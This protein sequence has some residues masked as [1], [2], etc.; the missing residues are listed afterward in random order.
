MARPRHKVH[1][2]EI[3][4]PTFRIVDWAPWDGEM[5]K[6]MQKA[7]ATFVAQALDD[8]IPFAPEWRA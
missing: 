8:E 7:K 2:T 4:T 1:R 5:P 6:V 3:V